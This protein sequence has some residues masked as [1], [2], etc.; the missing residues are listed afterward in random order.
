MSAVSWAISVLIVTAAI[1]K[2]VTTSKP[3]ASTHRLYDLN[4]E[5]LG[6]TTALSKEDLVS[7]KSDPAD[8]TNDEEG[9]VVVDM[10]ELEYVMV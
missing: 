6:T 3:D 7:A 1:D 8:Y 5:L 9:F 10:D 2:P 4:N